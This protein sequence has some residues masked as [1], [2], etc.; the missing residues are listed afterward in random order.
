[1]DRKI[2]YLALALGLFL[3]C[4]GES[5]RQGKELVASTH[6]YGYLNSSESRG[7]K[8]ALIFNPYEVESALPEQRELPAPVALKKER[9]RKYTGIIKNKT[10]HDVSVP[11]G[12]SGATVVIPAK[13]FIEYSSWKQRF[14]LTAYYEGKPF[15][16]L[17]IYANPR[18]YAYACGKYDFIVE[19]V[20]DES[21]PKAKKAKRAKKR[22]VQEGGTQ[23]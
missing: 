17:K 20:K 19:I 15:Y 22:K 8:H 11:S 4:A 14:D 1:M 21:P 3:G 13:G 12:E 9:A 2:V 16:C 18:E 6:E 7:D 23:G 10:R 5:P